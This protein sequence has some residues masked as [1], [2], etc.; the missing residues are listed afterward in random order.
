MR[1]RIPPPTRKR[2]LTSFSFVFLC[3]KSDCDHT[4]YYISTYIT[5]ALRDS[6][7]TTV[8]SV[9]RGISQQHPIAFCC[10][11]HGRRGCR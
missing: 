3:L 11:G 1:M 6:G 7:I 4:H 8:L 5:C 10:C 9:S 2:G